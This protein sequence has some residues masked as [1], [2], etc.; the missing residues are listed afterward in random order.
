MQ[1]C[2]CA[3][4]RSTE[5]LIKGKTPALYSRCERSFVVVALCCFVLLVVVVVVVVSP[6]CSC[7]C[8]GFAWIFVEIW[9]R[10]LEK[11]RRN[12]KRNRFSK[13]IFFVGFHFLGWRRFELI[14]SAQPIQKYPRNQHSLTTTLFV[15]NNICWKQ[16]YLLTATLFVDSNIICWQQHYLLTATLFVDSNIICWQQHYLLTATLFVDNNIIC[17]KQHYLQEQ[18]KKQHHHNFHSHRFNPRRRGSGKQADSWNIL[19]WNFPPAWKRNWNVLRVVIWSSIQSSFPPALTP[20]V[21]IAPLGFKCP[22]PCPWST[23]Q[24]Y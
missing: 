15:D 10:F 11:T 24:P 13:F 23:R 8:R 19:E 5:W 6:L 7:S 21:S 12:I 16:H 20:S 2:T 18:Q 4:V 17:W 22:N 1:L 14:I 9:G 3:I